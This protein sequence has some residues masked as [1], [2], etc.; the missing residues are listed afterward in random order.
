LIRAIEPLEG[1][2]IMAKFRG[3][4]NPYSIGSGPGK[5]C[6]AL[7]IDLRLNNVDLTNPRSPLTVLAPASEVNERIASSPRIGITKA[8]SRK[9]R[10]F[11][12]GSPFVSRI[13]KS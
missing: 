9:W 10:F 12:S 4:S 5:I 1:I 2:E 7:S 3:T 11:F 6:Q 8:I 13:P